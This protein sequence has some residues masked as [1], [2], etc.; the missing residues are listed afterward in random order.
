MYSNAKMDTTWQH[1][2]HTPQRVSCGKAKRVYCSATSA[3]KY[4]WVEGVLAGRWAEGEEGAAGRMTVGEGRQLAGCVTEEQSKSGWMRGPEM[5]QLW[6]SHVV[7][8]DKC[9]A[10]GN[11]GRRWWAGR[12]SPCHRVAAMGEW[13]KA[14]RF[15]FIT[16]G[17]ASKEC[18]CPKT[19]S[20]SCQ[21]WNKKRWPGGGIYLS[22][23]PF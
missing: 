10:T 1:W 17:P 18:L 5:E 16:K 7:T 13:A 15:P 21:Q 2:N 4:R 3:T 22:P 20:R 8:G 12:G 11:G 19:S 9:Q 23:N 6:V 14:S